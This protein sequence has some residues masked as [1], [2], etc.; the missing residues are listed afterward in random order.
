MEQRMP[1]SPDLLFGTIAVQAG[2]LK[3]EQVKTLLEEQGQAKEPAMLGELCLERGL[4]TDDQVQ[5][6]LAAQQLIE[7]PEG[8]RL[9]GSI[10]V[11]NGLATEDEIEVALEA[12]KPGDSEEAPSPAR[13]GEILQEMGTL[14]PQQVAALLAVQTRLRKSNGHASEVGSGVGMLV[15]E[16][17]EP[18]EINGQKVGAARAL[19]PGDR[20][21]IGGAVFRFD[22]PAGS[23]P[24]LVPPVAAKPA[25]EP[26]PTD[27]TPVPMAAAAEPAG[28]PNSTSMVAAVKTDALT[29]TEAQ[30]SPKGPGI[31]EKISGR[32]QAVHGSVGK[33]LPWLHPQRV[34]ILLGSL[35]LL[36]GAF[37]PW[38][39]RPEGILWGMKTWGV[40]TFIASLVSL[41]A[42]FLAS[43]G[44]PLPHYVQ[45]AAIYAS[46]LAAAVAL[47]QFSI[48]AS[49]INIS[50]GVGIYLTILAAAVAHLGAWSARPPA[51]EERT[52]IPSGPAKPAEGAAGKVK[53]K[54]GRLFRDMT[55]KRAKEKA[56]ALEKRD[57]LLVQLAEAALKADYPGPEAD[58]AKKAADVLETV[59]SS[60][61]KADS[62]S[63]KNIV[64]AKTDL[65]NAEARHKRAV[66]KLGRTVVD[67][68]PI[69]EG[70]QAK[71]DEV[72]ALDAVV[73]D[74]T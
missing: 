21:K 43:R 74:L 68:G 3:A 63:T 29:P 40:L 24:V 32:F 37:L 7:L 59:K 54:L 73:K 71:A 1:S 20:L 12:Q 69:P 56:A 10:A 2:Y 27:T 53:E 52:S 16:S 34:Y 62:G 46:A 60:G 64:K 47:W 61:E 44:K 45:F 39:H 11:R 25:K 48:A 9:L 23:A 41:A 57:Q 30:P 28:D 5:S 33:M 4:L 70:E 13:I 72:K 17:G 49:M 36:I 26:S 58:S 66:L 65:K 51:E 18:L 67:K 6:V 50:A 42:S 14:T 55:G 19:K 8:Q 35:L 15:Q 22:G 38:H 31:V